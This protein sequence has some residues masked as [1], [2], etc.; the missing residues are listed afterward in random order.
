MNALQTTLGP[1][2]TMCLL[3]A[4]AAGWAVFFERICP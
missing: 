1:M 3:L 2:R 4:G